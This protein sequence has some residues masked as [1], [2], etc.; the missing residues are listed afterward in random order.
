M[1]GLAWQ[2]E[3]MLQEDTCSG[4]GSGLGSLPNFQV[5]MVSLVTS[6]V[7]FLP[8]NIIRRLLPGNIDV[9][10]SYHTP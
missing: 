6:A 5:V 4:V 2:P 8:A 1:D 10:H 3:K 7:P 9:A